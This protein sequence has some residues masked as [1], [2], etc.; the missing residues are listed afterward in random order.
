MDRNRLFKRGNRARTH[1]MIRIV[2]SSPMGKVLLSSKIWPRK[3]S[4]FTTRHIDSA[5][6][7]T[8]ST[9]AE[10]RT[11]LQVRYLFHD[12]KYLGQFINQVSS[13]FFEFSL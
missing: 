4:L 2:L 6:R 10:R 1:E 8:T 3:L 11:D 13:L 9:R 7:P 5:R 12:K